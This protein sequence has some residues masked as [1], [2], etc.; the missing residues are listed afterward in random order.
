MRSRAGYTADQAAQINGHGVVAE[1]LRIAAARA[2]GAL[3]L[4]PLPVLPAQSSPRPAVEA[5]GGGALGPALE[6][7]L[8]I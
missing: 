7:Q 4:L 3:P 1:R 2:D 8:Y 6:R 5:P